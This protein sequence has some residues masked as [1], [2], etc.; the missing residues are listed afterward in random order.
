MG[1]T[2]Q[3][4]RGHAEG[5]TW[6]SMRDAATALDVSVDTV[7]RRIHRGELESRRETIASG[8]RWVVRVD[9][10]KTEATESPVSD[11]NDNRG[12]QR[13]A[14]SPDI[15]AALLR[16]LETRNREI[17]ARNR[18]IAALHASLA[19]LTTAV[20]RL[21]SP[22]LIAGVADEAIGSPE[23]DHTSDRDVRDGAEPRVAPR[24]VWARL[25]R[26][27]GGA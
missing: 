20:D 19:A 23:S 3:D 16:E 27:W 15:V 13:P 22:A 7:R 25:R 5:G 9:S 17:E 21:T 26:W 12:V 6:V 8:F 11:R 18:E 4:A 10:P 14:D 1:E 2:G 24:G